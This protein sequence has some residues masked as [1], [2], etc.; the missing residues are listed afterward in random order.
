MGKLY[1]VF[2]LF[3]KH[4]FYYKKLVLIVHHLGLLCLFSF[5]V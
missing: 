1:L 5:L 4:G 3:I 2:G